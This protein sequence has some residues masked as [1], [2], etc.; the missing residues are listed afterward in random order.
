MYDSSFII[1]QRHS[2][3]LEMGVTTSNMAKFDTV[4]QLAL[5]KY[6]T[7]LNYLHREKGMEEQ[8]ASIFSLSRRDF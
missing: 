1:A 6:R 8:T 2:L 5:Q 3:H 7:A 4:N